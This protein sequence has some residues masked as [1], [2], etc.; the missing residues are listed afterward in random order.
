MASVDDVWVVDFGQPFPAEPAF[1]RPAVVVGPPR[2]FGADFPVVF[3]CPLTTKRRGLSLHVEV[4]PTA[5]N[6]LTEVSYVQCE[7]MRSVGRRR[8]IERLGSLEPALAAEVT[9]ILKTLLDH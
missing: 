1:H 6:G 3:V 8:L 2:T 7:L 9:S 4:V 5:H